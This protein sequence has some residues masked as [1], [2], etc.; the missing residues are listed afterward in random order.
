MADGYFSEKI[1]RV[2]EVLT[3]HFFNCFVLKGGIAFR[4]SMVE[5]K[6]QVG[7]SYFPSQKINYNSFHTQFISLKLSVTSGDH[8]DYRVCS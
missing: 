1:V 2:F 6:I 5:V 7:R 8:R 3:N 4:Q